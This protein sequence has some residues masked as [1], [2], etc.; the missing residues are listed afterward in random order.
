MRQRLDQGVRQG[1]R[2]LN[3]GTLGRHLQFG[4]QVEGHF[5]LG[6]TYFY[7]GILDKAMEN[8]QLADKQAG[9]ALNFVAFGLTFT[10]TDLQS[11]L[12]LCY[13]RLGLTDKAQ[14]I[15][16]RILEREPD[17]KVGRELMPEKPD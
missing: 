16:E 14:K 12:G 9:D 2:Q 4:Q 13:K 15:G 10:L 5:L 6:E 7:E 1:Q 17:N 3:R 8:Y 11:K